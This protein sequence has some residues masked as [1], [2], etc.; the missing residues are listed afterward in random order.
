[1]KTPPFLLG[2]A[3]LFWGWQ[4]EFRPEAVVMALVLESSR[5]IKARWEFSDDEFARIWTFSFVLLLAAVIYAFNN[6]GGPSGFSEL[7]EN[8]NVMSERDAGNASTMTADALFRWLPMIFFLFVAAQTF[9]PAD[10]ISLEIISPYLRSR[11]RKAKKRGL[12]LPPQRRFDVSYPYFAVC[13]FSSSGHPPQQ[14]DYFYYGLCALIAWALWPRRS[15]RFALP[16]WAGIFL[17]A[18]VAGYWGQRG[19]TEVVRMAGQYDP[20]LLSLLWPSRTDAKETRTDIGTI[21]RKKLSGKI[22]IRLEVR[23]GSAPPS[24]LRE[25]TYREAGEIHHQLI[26]EAANTNNDN[27]WPQVYETPRESNLWPLNNDSSA[28]RS[29]VTI[30]SYLT[31]INPNDKYPDGLLPLPDDCSRLESLKAYFVYQNNIGAVLC[32]GPHLVIFDARYGSGLIRDAPPEAN[33]LITNQD[34]RV[35]LTNEIPALQQVISQLNISGKSDGEKVLA[36][37]EYFA[38][39]FKYSLWQEPSKEEVTN[40]DD[41]L[42][43]FL[44]QTHSGHCE[45]FASATV[46]LLRE[47]GIPARY[48]V[49]Y[50]VHE[51]AGKGYVVRTRDAHAWC[52]YWNQKTHAWQNLDTT[53]GSWVSEEEDRASLFE[54]LSDVQ[55]WAQYQILKFFE[56]GH[57]NIREYLFWILIPALAFLL[58]RIFRSSRRHKKDGDSSLAPGWPGLDSEF[59]RL[60]QRLAQNGLPRE[61]GEPL[62]LWLARATNDSN[63]AKLKEPLG[64][65]LQLHYRYRFDPRGLN[66][67]ERQ[68]LRREVETCLSAASR[69]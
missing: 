49:G 21:G 67:S 45:Y 38:K 68:E 64:N 33:T 42:S 28:N 62:S 37:S 60:E 13:L 61:P 36:I 54:F 17:A 59:Y 26:W 34:L 43:R 63:F 57:S 69:R 4:T 22:V 35:T 10:G 32:E 66:P 8:P 31:E 55:S 25:A 23:N 16:V 39:N 12:P 29:V 65:V 27:D 56:Y 7:L 20:Q 1:M 44:L 11:M 19:F 53:P 15:H 14:T 30:A 47:L 24:Y 3:L 6:N 58:Y 51:V 5:F 18:S 9:S 40:N 50:Y 48:A 46:L 41:P 2:A 52:I